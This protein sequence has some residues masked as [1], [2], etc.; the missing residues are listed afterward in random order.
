MSWL[1]D[2]R[3]LSR[4]EF[5]RHVYHRFER[6]AVEHLFRVAAG[7]DSMVLGE[8]QVLGQVRDAFKVAKRYTKY[9]DAP[10]LINVGRRWLTRSKRSQLWAV[11]GVDLFDCGVWLHTENAV[12]VHSGVKRQPSHAAT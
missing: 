2:Q 3:G 6:D 1:A 11:R 7:L 12:I 8:D 5:G 4:R 10:A 9:E